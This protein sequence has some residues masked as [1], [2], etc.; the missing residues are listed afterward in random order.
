MLQ[1]IANDCTPADYDP[2]SIIDRVLV[3]SGDRKAVEQDQIPEFFTPVTG[4]WKM[5][6][7]TITS[8]LQNMNA[9]RVCGVQ[10]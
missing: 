8:H 7:K 3:L 1:S 4:K 9:D 2:D 6:C 10:V 5:K